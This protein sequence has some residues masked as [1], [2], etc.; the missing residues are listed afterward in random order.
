MFFHP[1]RPVLPLEESLRV[2]KSCGMTMTSV[3]ELTGLS[4]TYVSRLD[5]GQGPKGE[6]VFA[7]PLLS[8]LA[9]AI[10][11]LRRTGKLPTGDHT[12]PRTWLRLARAALLN[13]SFTSPQEHERTTDPE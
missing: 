8:T 4:R 6:S 10:L 13:P 11:E 7:R 9:Y 1:D 3:A 12:Y 5:R 2:L